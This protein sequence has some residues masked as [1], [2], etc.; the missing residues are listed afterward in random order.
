MKLQMFATS[1]VLKPYTETVRGLS[2]TLDKRTAVHVTKQP[3]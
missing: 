1:Q 3:L 2:L